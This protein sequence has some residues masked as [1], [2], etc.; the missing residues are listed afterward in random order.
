MKRA[1]VIMAALVLSLVLLTSRSLSAADDAAGSSPDLQAPIPMDPMVKMG[2]FSNGLRYYIRHNEEPENRGQFWLA[3]NAGSVLEDDDQQGLAHFVEHMAFN[4]TE[5]FSK[6]ELIEYMES[7]GMRFGPELNAFTS[8]D[9]TVYMLEVPTDTTEMV[10]TAFQILED[11]AHLL[12][13]DEEEIDKERGVIGEEWR[14]GRGAQMRMLDEQLP[15]LFKDSRYAERLT[16]GKKTV[17]DTCKYDT[18]RR[19]Y[20]D[21]YRPDLMAVIAVGDFDSSWIETLINKHFSSIPSPDDPRTR[22]IFP[23]P[24]H[25]E[26]LFAIAT[27]PEAAQT[28]VAILFKSD[29]H[30]NVTVGDYKRLLVERLHDDILSDRLV[31]LTKKAEPPYLFAFSGDIPLTRAKRMQMV[32]ALVNEDG[33]KTGFEALLRESA[34][35]NR[36]GFTDSELDRSKAELSRS[37]ESMF[38]ERDKTKSVLFARECLNYFLRKEPMPGIQWEYERSKELLP[39]ITIEEANSLAQR[40]VSEKNRVV[41][42]GAPEKAELAVPSEDQLQ[43]AF[44]VVTQS[45]ILPY[46]D[47]A[48]DKPLIAAEPAPGEVID[49]TG[50]ED[51]GITEWKLSNG[52][53]VVLKPTDFKNDEIK[54]QAYS[55]G[56]NSLVSNSRFVSA[57]SAP[58]I[59]S[60]SGVGDFTSIELEK[61]LSGKVVSV[62][63]YIGPL[64]EGLSGS[65]SPK[66]MDTMFKLIYLYMTSPREDIEAFDS[67]RARMKGVIENRSASPEAAF[68]DTLQVT[69]SQHHHRLRP[70][71]EE[72]LA[73][74]DLESAYDFYVDRFADADDFVFFFVGNF[75][76]E[77]MR[78]LVM[79][80]LGSLP[81][82]DRE[83]TWRDRGVR[84]PKGIVKKTVRKG[85]EKKGRIAIAFTG[86]FEWSIENTYAL[87]SLASVMEIDLREM[88]R[89]E[90]GG[91]YGVGI[92]SEESLFPAQEYRLQISFGC[93][94]DRIDELAATVFG[95]IDSLRAYGPDPE[96]VE[97]IREAQSREYEVNLRDNGF[98]LTQLYKSYFVATDPLGVIQYPKLVQN[99]SVEMIQEA[100]IKYLNTDNY[101]QI[102]LVPEE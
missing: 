24:D 32:A 13:F 9:E 62:A 50:I 12:S 100:A 89:E 8:F 64:R 26:T 77:E 61:M 43:A 102:V 10:E 73:E 94:P 35:A 39:A 40:R 65:A 67:F 55:T 82:T 72:L 66:D 71:T 68:M 4:G 92:G 28:T 2:Q 23:V 48:S 22:Q 49:E 51:L 79:T 41:M 85:I 16:I 75:K 47:T 31:E 70:W 38:A 52:V 1:I 17:I 97:R 15:V 101:V 18:L 91:T 25:D 74:I 84:P 78:P 76:L 81:A 58:M 44:D 29:T 33:I 98:W 69:L 56:G 83:E 3:V 30:D 7:I 21:W 59:V 88:I 63:P 36:H 53:R 60:E 14:L 19:F 96:Y 42:V 37:M 95:Q 46:E 20:R 86:T 93:D 54:F 45:E 80:Y 11:W 5:H 87:K 27:D 6:N 90:L 57:Q 34:R 99:L